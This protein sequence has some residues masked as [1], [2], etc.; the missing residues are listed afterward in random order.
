MGYDWM[1]D[2]EQG[3][4]FIG[5]EALRADQAGGRHAQ[6]RRRRDRGRAAR[7]PTTTARWSTSLGST[8]TASAS[9][10]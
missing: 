9:A 3:S 5:K 7:V 1:V 4:D 6:A 2:L 8:E 10:R